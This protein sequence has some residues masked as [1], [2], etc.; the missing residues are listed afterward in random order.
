MSFSSDFD[1]ELE[2]LKK[3]KKNTSFSEKMEDRLTGTTAIRDKLMSDLGV[4]YQDISSF[5]KK[6]EEEDDIAP[7]TDT[8]RTWFQSGAFEDGYQFG[9]ITKTILG[10]VQDLKEDLYAGGL[11]IV[12]GA[13]DAAV[14]IAPYA[15]Q[16][17]FL[18]NGGYMLPDSVQEKQRELIEG[19]KKYASE[20]VQK[21]LIDEEAVSK[22]IVENTDHAG[23]INKHIL[24]V[25]TEKDSVFGDKSDSLVQSAGQLAATSSLAALGVPWWLTTGATSYGGEAENA[26][27]Q[28]ATLEEA[29]I[30]GLISAGAEI[31]TEKISGGI[32]I[33]GMGGTLDDAL[34][35]ILATK[36]SNK[37]WR[38]AA[39]FG[40]DAV[41]EGLEEVLSQ[42]IS[43][44][45][46]WLTYQDDK[47][48]KELLFSEEAMDAKIEA[49]IG[50]AV[51]GGG[52]SGVNIV[53]SAV[54]KVDAVTGLNADETTVA[55][56]IYNEALAEKEKN[57]KLTAS[58]KGKLWDSIVEK[59][60]KGYISAEDVERAL[61]GE[62]Y[63]TFK[64]EMDK[65]G[66]S[67]DYKS[68][69]A[70]EKSRERQLEKLENQLKKLENEPNTVGNSKKY[71]AI[72][73][74][75]EAIKNSTKFKDLEAR[76]KQE[77]GRIRGIRDAM[78]SEVM[79]RVKDS[80]LAESYRELAR[81][82][83]KFEVDINQYEGKAKETVQKIIDSG[84]GDNTNQFHDTVDFLAK[85]SNDKGVTFDFTNNAKLK[86]TVH[87]KEGYITNGFV[88]DNGDIM[89]N[90]D[91]KNVLQTTVGHEITHVLEKTDSYKALQAAVRDYCI[92]KEGLDKYNARVKAAEEAYKGK[93]NTTVDAEVTADIIGE[94]LFNDSDF[95]NQLS[96]DNRNVFEKIYD[97]IKYLWN[98]ATAGSKEKRDLEKVKKLFDQAWRENVKGKPSEETKTEAKTEA[99]TEVNEEATVD[100]ENDADL[101]Y[102]S[103]T[104]YSVSVKDQDTIDFLENQEHITTYKAMILVDGKLYPPMASKVKGEDGK[105]HMTNPRELGEWMQAEEDTTNI[106]FN[107]KGVGYY[108]LKK[109]DGG[110]VRAAYNPYEHSSN[111]VLNDQFEAA[112]KRENLVTVECVIPVSEMD[113]PYKAEY[114]KDSTGV[115][116]W[117]SGVV[118]GKLT[119][120]KRSVYLSRYLKAVRIVPDSEVAQKYKEIVGD[121]FVPFNV[122]SPGLLTELENAGVNIDYDG[123]PQYQYLQRRAAEKEAK[124]AEAV[125]TLEGG[126]VA[127]YSLST[128]TPDTQNRVKND[129][130]DAGF[131]EVDID[132]WISDTNGVAAVIASDKARLDFEAADNQVMLKDNQEYIKTLDASTLC[133]KR[134]VY[135][136][137]F[138]AIQH[139]MPNRMLSSDD[140]I[141]LLNMMKANGVQTPCGVC[142]VES[143][144]RHLGK[145]AQQWLDS[146]EGEYKPRLDELTTSD[147]LEKLRKSHYQAYKD[148]TDAMSKKG[149]SNPKVVQLRTEYRNDIMSL[150]PAQIR[151]IEAIGGLRVQSFSDFETPHLLDMMQAVMD[152]SA[153]GLHS[154]AYTKVPNFAWVFGDTGIKINLSLIAEGNGFDADGNLAFSSTEGMDIN[155]AMKL[156]DAYSK[157]VG[158]IIVGANDAHILACMADDRIDYIIPF[159]RSGWGMNELKMMGMNSYTDYTYGQKE[160]D[161][162][163]PTKV[164]NGVQQYAGLENLYPPDYWNYELSGKENAERYLNLCAKLGR[165]PKFAQFLVNNGDGSYRLQPD[166]S[167]DGYWK[168]LIDFKMY[169]NDGK[170]AAQQ[171][172]L[173]NFNMDE[174]YRVLNEYE[175]GANTLPVA[176]EIVEKFVA[177]YGGDTKYSMT[178]DSEGRE[179]SAEQSEFFKD[180]KVRNEA[181]EL[182]PMYHGTPDGSFT[183]FKILNL[184]TIMSAQGAG[185]YFTDKKNAEQ[186][187][188]AVNKSVRKGAQKKLYEVYLNITNPMEI[189][190]YERTITKEQFKEVLRKGNNNW[191]KTDW[192]P[193]YLPGDQYQNRKLDYE[194]LLDQYTERIFARNQSDGEILSEITR[195]FKGGDDTILKAMA[196][197]FGNDGVHFV[198][199]HGEIWVAWSAN[200]IKNTDNANPTEDPDIRY[201][202]TKDSTRQEEYHDY[203][204]AAN[205][206]DTE[207]AQKLL[208]NFAKDAG[209][210]YRGVHRS[211]ANFTVFDRNKVGSNG[212]TQLGDGFYVTLDIKDEATERYADSAY[213]ENRMDLYIKMESP[214]ILGTPMDESIVNK[215]EADFSEYGWFGEDSTSRYAMTPEKVKQR[216]LSNDGYE[217]METIRWI[218]EKNYMKISELMKQYGFDSVISENDYV[219][220][221][222]V[223][224]ES[225]L[226]S[227]DP[228]TY[229]EYGDVILPYERF[230][231]HN[232]DIRYSISPEGEEPGYGYVPS[233]DI[234]MNDP[235]D[236]FVP[237]MDS[238]APEV[239]SATADAPIQVDEDLE[240]ERAKLAEKFQQRREEL[241]ELLKDKNAFFSKRAS[242]LYL[243][244]RGL[245]KG[246]KASEALS[247]L[248]DTGYE[249]SSIRAALINIRHTPGERVNMNSAVESIARQMLNEEYEDLQYDLD[250]LDAEYERQAKELEKKPRMTRKSLQAS[251]VEDMRGEFARRGMDFDEVLKKAKNLST[252]ATVDN[253]P[254]RVMEKALGYKEGNALADLT[255]N[256]VAQNETEGIKWLNSITDRKNGLLARLSKQYHIKPGSKES[257]AAQM[258]AEGF[259][260]NENNELVE[261]GDRELAMDFPNVNVQNNIKGLAKDGRIRKFYDETL[262]KI[263]ESRTRNLYPEIPRLDNYHLHFRAMDDTFSR[264]GLPFNPNDIRAKDLPTDLNGVTADLKPGQP[265]FASAMHR[266][267]KRT[268]FDILGGLERYATSAKNQIYH[269]DD[270]QNLRALRNHLADTYGQANGLSGLDEL[271]EE[272]AQERI[273]EVYNSHL[274]TFAKF[275]NEEANVLAGKTALIDRGLEGIIGRRGITFLDTINKQVG[276]NLIGY[277]MSSPLTNFDAIPRAF[278]KTNKAD[279]VKAFGQM[280]INMVTRRSDG[281]AENSPVIIRRKGA[282][283]FYRT[284]WQKM[285]DP[286]Y[287]LM[288]KVDEISTELIARAK[289]NELTR[290]GMDAQKAHF[291]TDKWVSKLMGDRSMGQQ[292]QLFNSK[293]LGLFTK[294]Q[295]EVRNNLDSM[296]YDSIQEAKVS[297]EDIQNNLER[298]AKTA[299]K[300]TSTIAGLAIAQ[301]LFGTAFESVAG[302]NPSFDIIEAIIKAFGMDDDEEEPVLDNLEEAFLTLVDDLPYSSTFTGGR[303]PIQNALPIAE[304]IKGTDQYGNEK[305]RWETL[306]EIAPY[307]LLPGGYGQIKKTVQG[308][309]MYNTEEN[310]IPGLSAFLDEHPIAGSYNSSGKLRF[311]VEDDPLSVAQAL[312]FGQYSSKNARDYFD[313]EWSALGEKQI[314]EFTDVD[315]PY[316]DYQ[317]YR[318]GLKGLSKNSEYADYIN[319]LDIE[320]WQKNLLMNNILDRDEDVDMSD[321]GEYSGWE[322]FDYAQK[323]PGK[324]A[325][326]HAITDWETYNSYKDVINNIESDKKDNGDTIPGSKKEKV[327]DY[328]NGLDLDYGQKILLFKSIYPKDDTYNSDIFEYV[329]N[330]SDISYEDKVTILRE[331]GFTVYDNGDV[332]WD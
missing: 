227:A 22:W 124:K 10:S 302:Y 230:D 305:S 185:Y 169:D 329:K 82:S 280:A 143:R 247:Y 71:D 46:Q 112:Y 99:E 226:K 304:L 259:Y 299:A 278:V 241:T 107:D 86:G 113:A 29:N 193:F 144:R 74:Q 28:G 237:G 240:A 277:S 95:V 191:F 159:H 145:F 279:F 314:D 110:T 290:K 313:N 301:H 2:K 8:K 147:G 248:L 307:Y 19:S 328:I 297:N 206:G 90:K 330:R 58:E 59:M 194:T 3:K 209:Y 149:S 232:M 88:N 173:P 243:E 119:D 186:Y 41:G 87:Y 37:F 250:D 210:N 53:Q 252:F 199:R 316:A 205:K 141:D 57:G 16:G 5:N 43:A 13:L 275:L 262:D 239:E 150:T 65:F 32:K 127:K 163:K 162:N 214:F 208:D 283:R 63:E 66:Q 64:A 267:G 83:Q 294:F 11:G 101:D 303:I 91:S 261:Y 97:E 284:A 61:G 296:F 27:K 132:K 128:W 181:G 67:E 309:S 40:I 332:Y 197:V 274:S 49:F 56:K 118:A 81:K 35:G 282:D 189:R 223:Y 33:P 50:G 200:Q 272:E 7:A 170:G 15:A 327:T 234:G 219:K 160:H 105:Y 108:D 62:S 215:M 318:E 229:D 224:D 30:S 139:R 165:E 195:A 93:K 203:I 72:Q 172:V 213:G 131:D 164:I 38:T 323:N 4:S 289:Y 158:T 44:F 21:E 198:D 196:E 235:L 111:L 102:E 25:E 42:D 293:M 184:N 115:M 80:K 268:S 228:I 24:G 325:V 254:Q 31:L 251:L 324:H 212:G 238:F 192:M 310:P 320:D 270:I 142:Y 48:L 106:K 253:T 125:Q 135:Q 12:E 14:S 276:S 78:R 177:K 306:A 17:Q 156:R 171:K 257:A 146:Y 178:K 122:V 20:F 152:M 311:P 103:P 89:L 322:E 266:N 155:E 292:P 179:L 183:E 157:N 94:Y 79:E 202:M 120:N 231:P 68:Y 123:S 52:G 114:A 75:I 77:G 264:L 225:Q 287:A 258:Y 60:E 39:K 6:E 180:S 26:L 167:T 76:V 288:G 104:K 319:S 271:T 216:L 98:V 168:T 222:V 317:E 133:A 315:L 126:S 245:K 187:T 233:R 217:Q 109:D 129:L 221:A 47:T 55:E 138:D 69:K 300:A 242:E 51:L 176:Q 70:I 286:G 175:G 134:L 84:L 218:A 265:Y 298:N 1:K 137:T 140:L 85:I 201:S 153:K 326:S 9:D 256:K 34:T 246:V 255:V 281:F 260:V 204:D 54:N 312:M 23:L 92:S 121:I 73:S 190:P 151:K 285:S 45:G 154:Q 96:V 321:Y 263:N 207:T 100:P 273:K 166:G 36:I 174:A 116:D 136:G 295:L 220:Q 117:H 18:V 130:L 269:I 308:L 188:K 249:W 161:L 331:L 291:E 211:F 236:E 148:F 244:L 182:S